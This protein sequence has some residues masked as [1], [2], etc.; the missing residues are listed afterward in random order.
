MLRPYGGNAS[1]LTAQNDSDRPYF[2]ANRT[3][4]KPASETGFLDKILIETQR[5]TEKPDLFVRA[6]ALQLI[7]NFFT[8]S[9]LVNSHHL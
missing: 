6:I 9:N 3:Y 8:V 2:R 1:P 7:I 4:Q 5:L